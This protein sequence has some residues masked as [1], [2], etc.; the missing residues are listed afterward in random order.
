[1]HAIRVGRNDVVRLL[2]E[3][4]SQSIADPHVGWSA[5]RLAVRHGQLRIVETL[6][7]QGGISADLKSQEEINALHL[8]SVSGQMEMVKFLVSKCRATVDFICQSGRT[9]LNYAC[10]IWRSPRDC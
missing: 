8:A 6:V 3:E 10:C 2:V 5:L 1:M 9:A 4:F 7:H